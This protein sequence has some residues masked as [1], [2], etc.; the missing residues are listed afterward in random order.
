VTSSHRITAATFPSR[1]KLRAVTRLSSHREWLRAGNL[2]A[3]ADRRPLADLG[4]SRVM[5]YPSG[6][7]PSRAIAV[8]PS[9]TRQSNSAPSA[10]SD[11]AGTAVAFDGTAGP[12]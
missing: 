11:N 6:Q 2:G 9:Q 5:T 1:T 10:V 8:M 7:A 3:D 12:P 4:R